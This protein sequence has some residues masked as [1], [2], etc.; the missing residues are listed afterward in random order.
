MKK[1]SKK[2]I[3]SVLTLVLTVVALGTTTFAWFSLSTVAN[4]SNITGEVTAGEGIEVRLYGEYGASGVYA[5][6]W[7]ANLSETDVKDFIDTIFANQE[8]TAVTT[9]D[10]VAYK[11][12]AAT[13]GG[14]LHL[15]GNAEANVDYLKF[16]V[17][18]RSQNIVDVGLL[19]LEFVIDE[20]N[21]KVFSPDG[22][23]YV[24]VD[25]ES[26]GNLPVETHA[27]YAARVSFGQTESGTYVVRSFQLPGDIDVNS[28]GDAV[29]GN[30]FMTGSTP[31]AAGQWEYLTVSKGLQIFANATA[32]DPIESP[33]TGI[34]FLKADENDDSTAL[35]ALVIPVATDNSGMFEGS[36]DVRIWIEGWDADAY[37]AIY[38][39]VLNVSLTFGIV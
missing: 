32:S 15:N 8:L 31:I 37:D 38:A 6:D 34:T 7:K 35:E 36:V 33:F 28:A 20:N 16:E 26:A 22:A 19:S 29:E 17:Q 25:G 14:L 13:A 27:A 5:T 10:G 1:L 39:T 12:M 23:A 18:F 2:I 21:P 9:A 11:Q 24:Q 3:V 4:I 30:T